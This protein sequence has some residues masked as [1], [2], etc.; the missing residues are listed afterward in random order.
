MIKILSKLEIKG[1]FINLIK[2]V[3]QTLQKTT[4]FNGETLKSNPLKSAKKTCHHVCHK[5][6]WRSSTVPKARK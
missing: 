3:Y 2:G 1:N 5:L 6:H 4:Y